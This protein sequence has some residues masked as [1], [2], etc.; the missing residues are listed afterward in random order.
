MDNIRQ[1]ILERKIIY[2][3]LALIYD[4]KIYEAL[5]IIDENKL[6]E[7]MSGYIDNK[8]ISDGSREVF[9]EI[10]K[11]KNNE[12][13]IELIL[14]EY[15]RL[16]VGPDRIC[17]PLWK[18]VYGKKDKLLFGEVELEVRRFYNSFNLDVKDNEPADYLPRELYFMSHLCDKYTED[19]TENIN[20]EKLMKQHEFLR[21]HILSWISPWAEDVK[22]NSEMKF[23]SGFSQIIEGWLQNDFNEIESILLKCK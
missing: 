1:W 22:Q 10:E 4:G 7:H 16:F 2:F 3:I 15:Q 23:W 12:T 18:S 13:Y 14:K 19:Y 20:T 6:L 11:N 8:F 21:M 9:K 5:E 17:A